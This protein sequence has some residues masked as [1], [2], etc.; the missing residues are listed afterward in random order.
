[1]INVDKVL[2]EQ[3][4]S[5]N[6]R[7]LT[8]KPLKAILSN[9]LHEKDLIEFQNK[10]PHLQGIDFVEQVL[11]YFDFSYRTSDREKE[12]IPSTGKVVIIANHPIGSLD[13]LALLKLITD[14]RP[15]VKVVANDMLM[16][17][18]PMHKM[19]LP[20]NNMQGN[21]A[22]QNLSKIYNYLIKGGAVI[23]FPAGE[24][25]RLR[26]NG[27]RDTHWHSGF[28]RIAKA[29]QS[30][31]L[32]IYIDGRNSALFYS[33]SMLYKPLATMLLISEMFK[34]YQKCVDI[35]IGKLIPKDN[36]I[37][38]HLPYRTTISLF[39]KHVYRLGS[40]KQGLFK[41]HSPI[42]QPEDPKALKLAIEQ[43]E[44]LGSTLD[45][46]EIYLYK[47]TES[48]P[49]LREIGRLREMT[50]REIGE[51]TGNRRDTDKY[52]AYYFHL[53]LWD[54]QNLEIAGAYRFADTKTV[55]QKQGKTALYTQSLF[56]YNSEMTPYFEHGLELGRSFVQ[57][58]YWG[59]RSLDYLWYGIGA[60]INKN[61]K[62]R[63]LFGPVSI[64]DSLPKSAKDHLVFFYQL[65]FGNKNKLAE[66]NF[67]YLINKQDKV[68]FQETFTGLDHKADFA[69]LK[70]LIANMGSSIP[71]LYKQYSDL[72]EPGGV[73]FL[74][75]GTDPEFNDCI[76]GLVL[77]DL[78]KLKEKKRNRY[79]NSHNIEV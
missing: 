31:I 48:S 67:P 33:V 74:S 11:E 21:T 44:S 68:K 57:P 7:E 79:I 19:L 39:K 14:I 42:A 59:K 29:T 17:I 51:G 75:F 50:F 25:S 8:K 46:K 58:K 56:K 54:K 6:N 49:I 27:V 72:C 26:P 55:L 69:T 43:C 35:K 20:V 66:S 70:H 18:E 9:L 47:Y 22:T 32:P 4:P 37:N 40:N 1:M 2:A 60:F 36:Y 64:S 41:T 45:S 65:H 15:D 12:H 30:P 62:F 77:V 34:Q 38:H 28:Y 52:D 3:L 71:T 10:Y 63:Y 5:L 78:D 23:V 16:A 61:P 76:D 73:E 24:V 13:G 53:I